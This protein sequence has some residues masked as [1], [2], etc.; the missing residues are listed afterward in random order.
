MNK[1]EIRRYV[2]ECVEYNQLLQKEKGVVGS[3]SLFE[4]GDDMLPHDWMLLYGGI[5]DR[6]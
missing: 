1:F 2:T 3:I 5:R 4:I 6:Y